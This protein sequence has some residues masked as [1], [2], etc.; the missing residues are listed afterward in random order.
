MH[1]SIETDSRRNRE[2]A[3]T[4]EEVELVV[5][6]IRQICRDSS[7]EFAL[8]VGGVVIH[9]FYGGDV[10][11]WRSRGPKLHSFRRLAE[12]S[13]LPMSPAVLYRCV[14][15][16]EMC[17]RLKA[18]SRWRRLGASHLRTVIGLDPDTQQRLLSRAN[19]EQWTVKS[20]QQEALRCRSV[21]SPRGGRRPRS[22]LAKSLASVRRSLS[23]CEAGLEREIA[24]LSPAELERTTTLLSETL[25]QVAKLA[26]AAAQRRAARTHG[27][28]A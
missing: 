15:L 19:S 23:E 1:S 6:Q 11:A 7:L 22:T 8:R 9:H 13:E 26:R 16:F 27:H 24:A 21:A 14:A 2:H 3:L 25:E 17:E 4:E 10:D 20:L 18:P 28:A 5:A 12:H